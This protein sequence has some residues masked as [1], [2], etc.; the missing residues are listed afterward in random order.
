[1][2]RDIH[3]GSLVKKISKEKGISVKEFTKELSCTRGNIYDIFRRKKIEYTLLEKISNF[4]NYDFVSECYS[5]EKKDNECVLVI[6]TN[7]SK[8]EELSSDKS[9][10]ILKV[11]NLQEIIKEALLQKT[12]PK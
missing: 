10:R 11:I 9:V 8:I 2:N 7:K 6:R 5:T 12:S 3:I 4:L 1:M